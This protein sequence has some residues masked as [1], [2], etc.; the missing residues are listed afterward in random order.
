VPGRG[1]LL[2]FEGISK[3]RRDGRHCV[4]V[5]DGVSFALETG[6]HVGIRGPRR[7][8][9]TALLRIA[10]GLDAPSAGTV[11]WRGHDLTCAPARDRVRWLREIGFAPRT[12]R[13]AQGKPVVDHVA[14]PLL[15]DGV[16]LRSAMQRAH[17]A[18]ERVG[19]AEHAEAGPHELRPGAM[20]RV[21][22]ARAIVRGPRLLIVDEPGASPARGERDEL[23]ALL[24]GLARE[25]GLGLLVA[26]RE[27]ASL[28]GADRLLSLGD[29]HLREH[30]RP[31]APVVP[32]RGGAR[33][34]M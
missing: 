14:L 19:A 25:H 21:A 6:E 16:P 23:H 24:A 29:G 34:G 13:A 11:H 32:I 26:A 31:P 20:T 1:P 27:L 28:H 12:L 17:A 7:T 30:E 22:I 9:K 18:L 8:G 2:S 3:L 10:A 5:L 15:V 33:R 4:T